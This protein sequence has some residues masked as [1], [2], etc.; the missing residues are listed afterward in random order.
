MQENFGIITDFEI[1]SFGPRTK[2]WRENRYFIVDNETYK[3]Y[4]EGYKFHFRNGYIHYSGT[5]DGLK[6]KKLHRIIMDEPEGLMI[7]HINRIP[8]D[9]RKDNLRTVTNQQNMMNTGIRSDNTSGFTG[10]YWDKK[11]NKWE[12]RI[13]I[14]GKKKFLGYFKDKQDAI[15]TRKEAEIKYFKE[16]EEFRSK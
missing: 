13:T 4:V 11:K 7:D 1:C 9:N 8:L 5:K 6:N 15:N 12:A 10:V 2:E 16:F 14:N 3:N